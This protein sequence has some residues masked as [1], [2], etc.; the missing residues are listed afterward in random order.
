[1]PSPSRAR[2]PTRSTITAGGADQRVID[3][4]PD[5][6]DNVTISGLTITG[7][8]IA[9]SYNG[10]GVYHDVGN[11][12][13][14]HVVIT[15]NH[16]AKGFGGGVASDAETRRLLITDSVISGNSS[17]Y[18][19]GG[20]YAFY[21]DVTITGTSITGN[22]S[23][24]DGGGGIKFRGFEQLGL[25]ITSSTVSGN[26]AEA[27]GGG[28]YLYGTSDTTITS[29][30]IDNNVSAMGGGGIEIYRLDGPTVIAN[31]TISGNTAANTGGAMYGLAEAPVSILQSTIA[32]NTVG[33]TG[34]LHLNDADT[35]ITGTIIGDNHDDGGDDAAAT[36]LDT[37][38]ID[39]LEPKDGG[40]PKNGPGKGGGVGCRGRRPAPGS[41]CGAAPR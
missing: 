40:N 1:M 10:G 21:G 26:H 23:T 37:Q 41:R 14:D 18:Q 5:A 30:T 35:T 9:G 16:T 19:G 20:L 27:Y 25:T 29:S 6:D 4:N 15:D 2:A 38:F 28:L 33:A 17:L 24:G 31:S 39:S 32:G 12:T 34:G 8:N 36:D 7:G 11:L 22:S 3:V 13:L